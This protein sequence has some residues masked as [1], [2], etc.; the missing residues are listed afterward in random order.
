MY[1][2]SLS[3]PCS[4]ALAQTL[5]LLASHFP[6][7]APAAVS[8]AASLFRLQKYENTPYSREY[9]LGREVDLPIYLSVHT[10]YSREYGVS[11]IR[12]RNEYILFSLNI[13]SVHSEHIVNNFLYFFT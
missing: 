3:S 11:I 6:P 5:A 1:K 13:L 2:F 8:P 12:I 9:V 4:V 7:V 10:L